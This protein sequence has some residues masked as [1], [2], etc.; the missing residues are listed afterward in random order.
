MAY[1]SGLNNAFNSIVYY[2]ISDFMNTSPQCYTPYTNLRLSCQQ[3]R[4]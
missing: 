2:V 4:S 1:F 3:E